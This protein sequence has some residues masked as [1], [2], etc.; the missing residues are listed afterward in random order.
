MS[1]GKCLIALIPVLFLMGCFRQID[2]GQAGVLI[3]F[4][5]ASESVLTEGLNFYNP[6]TTD[7]IPV[8]L[9]QRTMVV[10]A[11]PRDPNAAV[12]SD[13]QTVGFSVGISWRVTGTNAARDLIQNL[14]RDQESWAAKMLADPMQQAI[15]SVFSHYT[16]RALIEQRERVRLEVEHEFV[17]LVQERLVG[18]AQELS[19]TITISQITL[20]N[21]DYSDEFEHM[22]EQTQIAQQAVLKSQQD[23]N[24]VRID[25]QQAVTLAQAQASAEVAQAKGRAMAQ[26]AQAEGERQALLLR[27]Q[28][29]GAFYSAIRASGMSPNLYRYTETWNGELPRMMLGDSAPTLLMPLSDE[30]R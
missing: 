30:V 16:L 13:V 27:A 29:Q 24:R 14:G 9:Q 26:I 18:Q 5:K 15:K 22:I 12:S 11:G 28:G 25:Q 1:K 17:R 21:L 20:N 4:G 2:T 8:S 19:S 3:R 6:W 23:L 10:A 7:I